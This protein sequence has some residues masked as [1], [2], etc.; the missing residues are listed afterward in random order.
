[1][2]RVLIGALIVAIIALL[3]GFWWYRVQ[4]AFQHQ[5][6]GEIAA[7]QAQV[8][9]LSADNETLKSQLSKVQEEESRLVRDND[10]LQKALE[11]ARLT[12]KVPEISRLPYPPK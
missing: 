4:T 8:N 5:Q 12:G 6:A 1:M 9:K 2:G 10:A 11:Q 7:L 3:I